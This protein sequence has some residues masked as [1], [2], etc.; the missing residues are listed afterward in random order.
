MQTRWVVA[1]LGM[2]SLEAAAQPVPC[3]Q[4]IDEA[5]VN[6]ALAGGTLTYCWDNGKTTRCYATDLAA[7]T[8]TSAPA[9]AGND[10]PRRVPTTKGPRL[11]VGADRVKVCRID[12]SDCTT[13]QPKDEVDE[14]LGISASVND[15]ATVVAIANAFYVETFNVATGKRLARFRAGPKPWMC[16]HAEMVGDAVLVHHAECGA[17]HGRSWLATAKGK[18]LAAVGGAKPIDAGDAVFVGAT[19]WA[20]VSARGDVVVIQDVKTGKVAKRI[21]IGIAK[22]GTFP[23][24]VGG[25]KQL[26]LI[27]GGTRAGD[28]AVIDPATAKVTR[29]PAKRCP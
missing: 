7:G 27:S 21:A 5:P 22:D 29:Y 8:T 3:V 11:E 25:A 10:L 13:F 19:E 1:V 16:N 23:V 18:K 24:L 9:P 26:A 2:I 6:V 15:T 20:F 17:E 4:A 14:G 12:G 28:I